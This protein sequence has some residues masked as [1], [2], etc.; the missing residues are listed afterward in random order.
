MTQ[1]QEWAC[2]SNNSTTVRDGVETFIASNELAT[3]VRDGESREFTLHI[4]LPSGHRRWKAEQ[5]FTCSEVRCE[6][7]R[8]ADAHD[9]CSF[10]STRIAQGAFLVTSEW[11]A[12]GKPVEASV[13]E[14]TLKFPAVLAEVP[15]NVQLVNGG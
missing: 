8:L 6:D 11:Q 10:P 13:D 14:E 5:G 15:S 9:H 7:N 3:T 12:S 2:D 4:R 1:R